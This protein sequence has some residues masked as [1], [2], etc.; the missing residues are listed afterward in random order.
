M[1]DLSQSARA[2]THTKPKSAVLR[3]MVSHGWSIR[4][5]TMDTPQGERDFVEV[6]SKISQTP[7]DEGREMWLCRG[8]PLPMYGRRGERKVDVEVSPRLYKM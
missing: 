5:P 6:W 4:S 7:K 8:P 1:F 2:R 3:L